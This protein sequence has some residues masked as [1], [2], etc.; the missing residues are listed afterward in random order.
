MLIGFDFG[1]TP[2]PFGARCGGR[3]RAAARCGHIDHETVSGLGRA[4]TSSKARDEVHSIVGITEDAQES[5]AAGAGFGL[6][7]LGFFS[8]VLAVINLFPFLP[9]DGG[10]VL[11]SLAE[12]VRGKRISLARDVPLQL[13]RDPAAAVPRDQRL[14]QRHRPPG[15]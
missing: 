13:G 6:V 11:W 3:R 15:G 9:L 10:H 12:K 1:A 5:V 7:F 8:L 4:L 2:S 14:Q